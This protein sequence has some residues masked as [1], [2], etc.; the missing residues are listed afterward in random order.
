MLKSFTAKE[1]LG[2]R[3]YAA[4]EPFDETR[5]DYRIASIVQML[6]NVNRDTNRK[7]QPYTI[8]E[9]RLKFGEQNKV[10]PM[11]VR[12]THIALIKSYAMAHAAMGQSKVEDL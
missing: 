1:L 2:W 3:A 11:L 8:D 5:Q 9:M 6:A 7:T 10:D 12:Q 4:L